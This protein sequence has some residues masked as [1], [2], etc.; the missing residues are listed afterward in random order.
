MSRIGV[1]RKSMAA[2]ADS[3]DAGLFS[4][5]TKRGDDPDS[6]KREMRRDGVRECPKMRAVEDEC[7]KSRAVEDI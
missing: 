2:R 6:N 7:L 5:P 1:A 4:W 3:I